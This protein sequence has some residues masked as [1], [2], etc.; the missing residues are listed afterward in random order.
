MSPLPLHHT[1]H[2]RDRRRLGGVRVGGGWM[3]PRVPVVP[4]P[5]AHIPRE[6]RRRGGGNV[7]RGCTCPLTPATAAGA[8]GGRACCLCLNWRSHVFPG[9]AGNVVPPAAGACT[10]IPATP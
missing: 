2:A 10:G 6:R 3:L 7:G 8:P 5:L 9:A 1:G 4:L